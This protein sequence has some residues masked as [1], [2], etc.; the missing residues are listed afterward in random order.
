LTEFSEKWFNAQVRI[1]ISARSLQLTEAIR[2]YVE[3]KVQKAQKYFQHIIWA[4]VVLMI[5]KRTHQAEIVIHASRQTFRA[6][7]R[8][9][10]LYAAID[11]ASDKVDAQLKKYKE[12]LRDH[13]SKFSEEEEPAFV[14]GG[15]AR[16]SVVKQVPMRPMTREE[17]AGQMERLGY[18]FWLFL[19]RTSRQV[20][21]VYRR[22]DDS[23]GVLQPVKWNGK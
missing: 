16:F 17:A 4:Q 20:Q 19:D 23:Y 2:S 3:E 9:A 18:D 5:Q 7:A 13:H 1:H 14:G 22:Q 21:L 11:L 6:L 10:D 15:P 12:R 8:G